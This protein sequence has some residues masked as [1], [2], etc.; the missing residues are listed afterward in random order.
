MRDSAFLSVPD[1]AGIV[2]VFDAVLESSSDNFV[3]LAELAGLRKDKDFRYENLRGVDF[4]DCDLRGFDFTG[5]CLEVAFG[6]E[7]TIWDATTILTDADVDGSLFENDR[8]VD[9][10]EGL[11]EGLLGQ[12]WADQIIWMDRLRPNPQ[13]YHEDAQKLLLVFLKSDDAFVR[14]TAMNLLAKYLSPDEILEIIDELVLSGEER[15][16]VAAAF[17]LLKTLFH[18][19]PSTVIKLAL[20]HLQGN[21]AAEAAVF[22]GHVL[23]KGK[24]LLHLS[25]LISRHESPLVRRRYITALAERTGIRTLISIRDQ[26]SGEVF[27]FGEIIKL[28][29]LDA[30]VRYVIRRKRAAVDAINKGL[31]A[32]EREAGDHARDLALLEEFTGRTH[33]AIRMQILETLEAFNMYGLKYRLPIIATA[34][35]SYKIG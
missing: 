15:T 27:D 30:S 3:H 24:Q 23:P 33:D 34:N 17:S 5:S 14:R 21:W 22:L 1:G 9:V 28:E 2:E 4:S 18:K 19:R 31:T 32:A 29:K 13:D 35:F 12:H 25:E 8:A 16:L 26:I 7:N 6:N 20:T 11:P 10:R